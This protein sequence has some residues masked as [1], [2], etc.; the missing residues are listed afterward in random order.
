MRGA[1][2]PQ[3]FSSPTYSGT[4]LP[5][6]L[7]FSSCNHGRRP[8]SR[9]ALHWTDLDGRC[10]WRDRLMSLP[11]I[12]L[13]SQAGRPQ[14]VVPATDMTVVPPWIF[15]IKCKPAHPFLHVLPFERLCRLGDT[16]AAAV[17]RLVYLPSIHSF[18]SGSSTSSSISRAAILALRTSVVVPIVSSLQF[19]PAD[20]D[21]FSKFHG[22][23]RAA[24][25]VY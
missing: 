14:Q 17:I 3:C 7:S 24:G 9:C 18:D 5:Q 22:H 6:P 11:V 15:F 23:F 10:Y 1:P 13:F 8:A 12:F 20:R 19:L 25:D 2:A 4:A 21:K 16:A